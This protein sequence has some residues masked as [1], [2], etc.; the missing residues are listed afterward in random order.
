MCRACVCIRMLLSTF[1]GVIVSTCVRCCACVA[2]QSQAA[3]RHFCTHSHTQH[4]H[5]T[6][7]I[8]HKCGLSVWVFAFDG[9]ACGCFQEKR[10]LNHREWRERENV[11]ECVFLRLVFGIT[12]FL[13][14]TLYRIRLL[15]L[16]FFFCFFMLCLLIQLLSFE[17][18]FVS[19]FPLGLKNSF[20]KWSCGRKIKQGKI[21]SRWKLVFPWPI[22][23]M[24]W[25]V[26]ENKIEITA[27]IQSNTD[28]YLY[29]YL[30][31]LASMSMRAHL[32]ILIL[33]YCPNTNLLIIHNLFI[34]YS[35]AQS[36]PKNKK[37]SSLI[38]YARNGVSVPARANSLYCC[39]FWLEKSVDWL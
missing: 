37:I 6:I 18:L 4:T 33:L 5:T 32:F 30:Y 9:C 27:F 31:A 11:C 25:T 8:E 22:T 35:S 14:V 21:M 28:L 26:D 24:R 3:F 29:L 17:V 20:R 7:V 34:V 19:H 36:H 16:L 15:S 2:W 39:W 23:M 10:M 13:H 1:A 38:L 12:N